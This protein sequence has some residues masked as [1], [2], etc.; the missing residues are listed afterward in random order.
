MV[1]LQVEPPWHTFDAEQVWP[2]EHVPHDSV[3]PQPFEMVPQFLPCA[4]HVV[5]VHGN[6]HV[7]LVQT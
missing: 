1:G 5:G 2:D 4:A 6:V 3:P 7:P